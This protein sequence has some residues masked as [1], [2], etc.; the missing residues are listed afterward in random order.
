MKVLF[1]TQSNEIC[2]ASRTRVYQY[3]P[4]LRSQGIKCRVVAMV[5]GLLYKGAFILPENRIKKLLY[6]SFSLI[7]NY[8]KS[9]QILALARYYNV[10][11]IQRI[12]IPK[13]IAC[14]LK[15]IND[16][17]VFDF[18]DAIYA[19]EGSKTYLTNRLRTY[20][21]RRYLPYMLSISKAVIVNNEY[22]KK[23]A[24]QFSKDIYIITSPIDT[25]RYRPDNESLPQKDR[26]GVIIGWIGSATTTIY[27]DS[28]KDVFRTLSRKY[29]ITLK[30]IG[31]AN[32]D[33]PE[34]KIVKK[35]WHLNTEV[36]E[37]QGFNIGIMP[38]P[39]DEWTRGKGGFK[40]LQ[41]LSMGIPAVATPVGIN[42]EIIKDGI[43]GFLVNSEE[44]WIEKLSLLIENPELRQKIGMAG[45]RTVEERFSV[46]V[47]APKYLQIL[48]KVCYESKK[49]N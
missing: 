30:L 25:Q 9:L 49:A 6:V 16:N 20:R 23:F 27:L 14:F 21:N 34:V 47:N 17:I 35:K 1:F 19:I 22:N 43:T 40:L 2:A 3:L 28:L 36:S 46:K 8:I 24:E 7:L 18:D 5:T 31:A 45:R 10:I 15:K 26:E 48:E 38:L 41:Y 11:F 13:A 4:F 44:E 32:F 39:D 33:I 29:K 37:L 12:V 42:T